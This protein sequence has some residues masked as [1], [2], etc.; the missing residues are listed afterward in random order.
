M[1][2]RHLLALLPAAAILPAR[3]H[4][5]WSSFDQNRPIYLEGTAR[6][7]RCVAEREYYGLDEWQKAL[8]FKERACREYAARGLSSVTKKYAPKRD[9]D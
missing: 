6:E 8:E 3:A 7:V 2:R 1:H 5:G 4:H 9:R